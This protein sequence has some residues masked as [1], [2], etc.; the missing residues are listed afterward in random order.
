MYSFYYI[1]RDFELDHLACV[2]V[3]LLDESMPC[4]HNEKLPFRVVPVLTF[5]N[6]GFADIDAHLA[7][8]FSVN[9]LREAAPIV[10]VH[11]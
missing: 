8:V 7:T 6:T 5:G 9:Q 4:Y 3:A 1:A 10:H 2:D 11:L